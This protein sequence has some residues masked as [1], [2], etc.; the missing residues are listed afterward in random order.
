MPVTAGGGVLGGGQLPPERGGI[1]TADSRG[2]RAEATG[3]PSCAS[4]G[5]LMR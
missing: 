1:L 2:P 5:A 4:H 3:I